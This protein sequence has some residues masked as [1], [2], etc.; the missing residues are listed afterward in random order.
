MPVS[1]FSSAQNSDLYPL[2]NEEV[3]LKFAFNS[4]VLQDVSLTGDTFPGECGVS[5]SCYLLPITKALLQF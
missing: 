2:Y 1:K 3:E 5:N 4:K